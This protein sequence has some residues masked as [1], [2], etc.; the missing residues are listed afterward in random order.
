MSYKKITLY[1]WFLT[2]GSL[3][4]LAVSQFVFHIW[5]GDRLIIPWNLSIA[6][7]IYFIVNIWNSPYTN[8]LKGMGKMN[9][10][11]VASFF[12]IVLFLPIA[13]AFL[14]TWGT[15]GMILAILLINSLPNLI[16]SRL[17]FYLIT[18]NKAKGIWNK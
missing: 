16:I 3:L 15:V 6:M 10:L 1:S 7:T 12:K 5:L 9:V 18:N 17:Q 14:K 11:V 13:I 8:F 2:F 4:L